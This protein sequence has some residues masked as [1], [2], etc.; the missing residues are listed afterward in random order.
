M[1]YVKEILDQ[2][3]HD[4][5]SVP[6]NT[7]VCNAIMMMVDR[8]IGSVLVMDNG[9]LKGLFTEKEFARR[10]ADDCAT[11]AGITVGEVMVST[12]PTVSPTQSINHCMSLMTDKHIRHLPVVVEGK[13]VGIVSIGDLV[14]AVISEQQFVIDQLE[15]YI[16]S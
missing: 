13:V 3:G 7:T 16:A 14:K 8:D 11:S 4:F 1:W 5:I 9:E 15:R 6:A 10:L 12:V 2:K